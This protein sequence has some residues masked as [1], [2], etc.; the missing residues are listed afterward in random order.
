MKL[1]EIARNIFHVNFETQEELTKT[2]IR[3]Q[4]H[5]ES[6]EF[7]GEVFTLEEYGAWYIANSPKG[8]ET[9]EFTYYSDWNGFNIPS[10]I[11]EPF[12]SGEFDPLS[13]RERA[14]LDLFGKHRGKQFYIIGTHEEYK[15]P[16]ENLKHE[17]AHGLF[18]T[19]PFYRK[20]VLSVLQEIDSSLRD[21][22]NDFFKNSGGYHPDVWED[23][24]HAFV[25][26]GLEKLEKRGIDISGL[27]MFEERLNSVFEK[28]FN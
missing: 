6:P 15:N 20:E 8:K 12:Y 19:N 21:K 25:L 14:L 17:M 3:F 28:Y 23:E 27:R 7:R 16:L 26:S 10:T 1:E 24:T 11:L 18:F 4:E 5:F 9:G 13:E 22:L 2:F